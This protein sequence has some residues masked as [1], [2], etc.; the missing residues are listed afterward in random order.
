MKKGS[1]NL[2]EWLL[3]DYF[4]NLMYLISI[5]GR[6]SAIIYIIPKWKTGKVYSGDHRKYIEANNEIPTIESLVNNSKTYKNMGHEI[7]REY[8]NAFNYEV[9]FE[10]PNDPSEWTDVTVT[11]KLVTYF[12]QHTFNKGS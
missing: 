10:G 11:G 9:W 3:A 12:I 6:S 4:N 8:L 1:L 7:M 2:D 5:D